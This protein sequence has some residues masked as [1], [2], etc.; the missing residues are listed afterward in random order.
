MMVLKH[1]GYIQAR[2]AEIKATTKGS[3]EDA[4]LVGQLRKALESSS[5]SQ[6]ARIISGRSPADGSSSQRL[7]AETQGQALHSAV[8]TRPSPK[9]ISSSISTEA[10]PNSSR[11]SQAVG[12]RQPQVVELSDDE[13]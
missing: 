2:I 12:P 4:I 8:P 7:S 11:Q 10:R 6:G 13:M 9:P 1:E 5:S 3:L